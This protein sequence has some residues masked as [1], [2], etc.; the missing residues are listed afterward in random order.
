MVIAQCSFHMWHGYVHRLQHFTV[1]ISTYA[2]SLIGAHSVGE[3]TNKQKKNL[4]T[5]QTSGIREVS[6]EIL[7]KLKSSPSCKESFS[8]GNH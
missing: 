4:K 6:L 8:S 2:N 1:V 3:K 5:K 7:A